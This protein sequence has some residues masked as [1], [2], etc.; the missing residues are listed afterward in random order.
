[1]GNL[2]KPRAVS[3]NFLN[4]N[5]RLPYKQ[6]LQHFKILNSSYRFPINGNKTRVFVLKVYLC[7]LILTAFEKGNGL[8]DRQPVYS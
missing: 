1:M 8:N 3:S 2:P 6:Y 5:S 4:N 7:G